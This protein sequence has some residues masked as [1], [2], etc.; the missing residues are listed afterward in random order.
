MTTSA[1]FVD[2]VV[3]LL[4]F[5]AGA[6]LVT[7]VQTWRGY[8]PAVN[9]RAQVIA[10]VRLESSRR[11]AARL[12]DRLDLALTTA[13][14]RLDLLRGVAA[15]LG[16]DVWDL[17]PVADDMDPDAALALAC[18]NKARLLRAKNKRLL[19]PHCCDPRGSHATDG[20]CP[21][22]A[23]QAGPNHPTVVDRV[24]TLRVV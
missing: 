11:E 2:L 6:V 21:L 8:D 1:L 17:G 24:E 4:V 5:S 22:C 20:L 3:L 9:L 15:Q 16:A 14:T 13:D 23:Y 10:S 18:R 7:L 19:C 12:R